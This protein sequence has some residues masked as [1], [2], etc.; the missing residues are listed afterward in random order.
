MM[1]SVIPIAHCAKSLV[2]TLNGEKFKHRSCHQYRSRIHEEQQSGMVHTVRN[3]AEQ[4]LFGMISNGVDHPG[5]LLLMYPRPVLVAAAMLDFFPIEGTH[6]TFCAVR[7][8]Y[9]GFHHADRMAVAEGNHAHQFSRKNQEAALEFLNHFNGMPIRHGLPPVKKLEDKALLCTKTGQL[10]LDFSDAR[11]LMELIRD[12]YNQH[13]EER[14]HTLARE[15][16]GK[17]Y[18]GVSTWSVAES[19][20]G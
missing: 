2:R 16:F 20:G 6:K 9:D 7:D 15:Y 11:S 12:Y 18:R 1:E 14:A 17:G 19:K 13:R 4:D 5:L 8:W 3:H 10:M